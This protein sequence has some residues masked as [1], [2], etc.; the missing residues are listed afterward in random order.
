[1]G[2]G[3]VRAL[4]VA[5][6]IAFVLMIQAWSP[7]QLWLS[8]NGVEWTL[9]CE[10]FFYALFPA[11][12]RSLNQIPQRRITAIAVAFSAVSFLV[13]AAFFPSAYALHLPLLR[14]S[15]FVAGV[16]IGMGL[17]RGWVPRVPLA[18]A[19]AGYIALVY[20]AAQFPLAWFVALPGAV[21]LLSAAAGADVRAQRSWLTSRWCV[22]L[23]EVSFCFYLV[24]EQLMARIALAG[25]TGWSLIVA[26]PISILA[27]AAL[28]HT[29]E[30][31]VQ[32]RL[33]RRPVRVNQTDRITKPGL[34]EMM[35]PDM[36]ALDGER[37]ANP[38]VTGRPIPR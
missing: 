33:A 18:P 8:Y 11:L 20:V 22:Y 23:G 34:A 28:H 15:E 36:A 29:V 7:G 10:A 2:N 38:A 13:A 32:G 12:R 30:L 9:S 3:R 4:D 25:V 26:L 5:S 27:A 6:L 1:M 19:A 35:M 14:L 37:I 17:K 16:A 31:P 24:H 21:L